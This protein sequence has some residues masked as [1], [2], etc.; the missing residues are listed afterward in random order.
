MTKTNLKANHIKIENLYKSMFSEIKNT[1]FKYTNNHIEIAHIDLNNQD[2]ALVEIT[3][4][5]S[6]YVISYWDGYSLSEVEEC[7]DF[8]KAQKIFKR[9]AKKMA[10][11]INKFS[12]N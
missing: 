9:F 6:E 12:R 2:A 11:N 8:I 4:T 1:C 10:K 5:E 7:D 3:E